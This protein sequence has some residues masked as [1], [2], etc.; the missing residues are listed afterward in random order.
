MEQR[1]VGQYFAHL[2]TAF[3]AHC[4]AS[5][6]NMQVECIDVMI[7]SRYITI[8]VEVT[9]LRFTCWQGEIAGVG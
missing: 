1:G 7:C 5:Q 4:T 2:V 6:G 9:F 8:D 3:Y